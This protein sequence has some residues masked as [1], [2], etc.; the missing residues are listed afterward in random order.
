[1]LLTAC[2][3]TAGNGAGGDTIVF[4][5]NK[6]A[7]NLDPAAAPDGMSLNVVHL[8]MEGLTRYHQGSFK[9]EPALAT[10]WSYDRT[11]TKWTFTC[12]T[13]SSFRT[14]RR[15]MRRR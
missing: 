7:V 15:S 14:A 3:S 10:S 4:G 2:S 8:M 12:A 9:V 1:M 6:D 5:R 13:T 11:G